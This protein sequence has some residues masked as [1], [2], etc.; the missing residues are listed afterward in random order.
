MR[1][2]TGRTNEELP[3]V[4][5][6]AVIQA[7][8]ALA[9]TAAA[10][11]AAAATPTPSTSRRAG[12]Q[13]DAVEASPSKNIVETDSGKIYGYRRGQIITFKGIPYGGPTDGKSRFM[14]PARP[15]PWGGVRSALYW[16][17]VSPQPFTSTLDAPRGG[18]SHDREA[19]A[20]GAGV[21]SPCRRAKRL[22]AQLCERRALC[23]KYGDCVG[24]T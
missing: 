8:S 21:V 7:A 17:P 11:A 20:L 4:S 6:R 5:R 16:G 15:L 1:K 3:V 2:P 9:G 24:G 12:R 23:Q 13:P 19:H 10:G 14:P 18:W 22:P